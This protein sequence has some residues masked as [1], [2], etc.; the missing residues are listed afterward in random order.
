MIQG[1]FYK[2][3]ALSIIL[4]F[5]LM[6]IDSFIHVLRRLFFHIMHT[7]KISCSKQHWLI[8]IFHMLRGSFIWLYNLHV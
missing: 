6:I 5:C 8:E 2:V 1:E 3:A 4:S 7:N